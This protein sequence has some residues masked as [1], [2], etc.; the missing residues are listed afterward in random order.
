[1]RTR[2]FQTKTSDFSYYLIKTNQ[3]Y[4]SNSKVPITNNNTIKI[5]WEPLL[6]TKKNNNPGIKLTLLP[7]AWTS[8]HPGKT[9]S[10]HN[11]YSSHCSTPVAWMKVTV[12][13][14]NAHHTQNGQCTS[15]CIVPEGTSSLATREFAPEP[16]VLRAASISCRGRKKH[17]HLR[18]SSWHPLSHDETEMVFWREP[19]HP[20]TSVQSGAPACQA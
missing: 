11:T 13:V 5:A 16:T 12:P 15:P 9:L 8:D 19:S 3:Q 6:V 1:M 10:S 7:A 2:Q 20:F 17:V 4:L 14:S 18:G